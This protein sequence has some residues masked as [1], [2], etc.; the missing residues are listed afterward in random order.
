MANSV[1]YLV[2]DKKYTSQYKYTS[3]VLG[4][5]GSIVH[6]MRHLKIIWAT[7]KIKYLSFEQLGLAIRYYIQMLIQSNPKSQS[8]VSSGALFL[9]K[10]KNLKMTTVPD[11]SLV[12]KLVSIYTPLTLKM[13]D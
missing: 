10:N 2:P 5:R 12:I 1:V 8:V 11:V 13:G 7:F 4:T 9:K 6:Y 3:T